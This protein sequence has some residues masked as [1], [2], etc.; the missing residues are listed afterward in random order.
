MLV[1]FWMVWRI[2]FWLVSGVGG[3]CFFFCDGGG[4]W[5]GFIFELNCLGN[6]IVVFREEICSLFCLEGKGRRGWGR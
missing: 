3:E 2:L 1:I 5:E 6:F 4:K